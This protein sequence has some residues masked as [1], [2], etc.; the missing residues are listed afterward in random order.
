MPVSNERIQDTLNLYEKHTSKSPLIGQG[1]KPDP[2]NHR[3]NKII[4]RANKMY[5]QDEKSI[6]SKKPLQEEVIVIHAPV[7]EM[8][9]IMR[10]RKHININIE[11]INEENNNEPESGLRSASGY[12]YTL[13]QKSSRF[14]KVGKA[15]NVKARFRAHQSSNPNELTLLFSFGRFKNSYHIE[16]LVHKMLVKWKY[17]RMREWFEIGDNAIYEFF[18]D[19]FTRMIYRVKG[20]NVDVSVKIFES[21]FPMLQEQN[22]LTDDY[23]NEWLV[24]YFAA[25]ISFQ[26]LIMEQ[27]DTSY[28]DFMHSFMQM[29]DIAPENN[30]SILLSGLVKYMR[31]L[32]KRK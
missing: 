20:V 27:S 30:Q 11:D 8:N 32:T 18:D 3:I 25:I 5:F 16:N 12:V 2:D 23:Y 28:Y 26:I 15:Y 10:K 1:A 17:K 9:G 31:G 7:D 13:Y 4:E 21:F 24:K 29:Y 14:V 19:S 6:M 22:W